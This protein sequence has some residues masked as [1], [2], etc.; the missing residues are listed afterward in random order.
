MTAAELR[1]ASAQQLRDAY[2]AGG[3][4]AVELLAALYAAIDHEDAQLGAW[5]YLRREEAQAEAL[6]ADARYAA[7]RAA[8]LAR[9]VARRTARRSDDWSSSDRDSS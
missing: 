9:G 5:L 8:T 1:R 7:A 3:A 6:A 4:T 2:K